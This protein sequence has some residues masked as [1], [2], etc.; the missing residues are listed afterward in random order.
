MS[1][2]MERRHNTF[3]ITKMSCVYC[4]LIVYFA[5]L[6]HREVQFYQRS[7][8]SCWRVAWGFQI[9]CC[10]GFAA[11]Q[12]RGQVSMVIVWLC[13]HRKLFRRADQKRDVFLHLC[14]VGQNYIH[15][16][17]WPEPCMCICIYVCTVL[18]A[19]ISSNKRSYTLY[20]CNYGQPYTSENGG[21]SMEPPTSLIHMWCSVSNHLRCVSRA[22][23]NTM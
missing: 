3:L 15:K 17:C 14:R 19:K 2:C 13:G 18:F 1:C 10:Q 5:A 11:W 6:I 12:L 23:V 7:A 8:W 16:R 21:L 4:I 22:C 20:I 9:G